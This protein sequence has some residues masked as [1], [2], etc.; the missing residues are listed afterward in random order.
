MIAPGQGQGP[1]DK[2]EAIIQRLPHGVANF[3]ETPAADTNE[4]SL[5]AFKQMLESDIG[6]LEEA[7]G[8]APEEM[9]A[10]I[11]EPL[12]IA[13]AQLQ[14]I[15]SSQEDASFVNQIN[16]ILDEITSAPEGETAAIATTAPIM[17]NEEDLQPVLRRVV[18]NFIRANR[19]LLV[20]QDGSLIK[21]I[22][23]WSRKS[24]IP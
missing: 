14:V 23:S 19:E 8:T 18:V 1:S 7:L 22:S 21:H 17:I 20:K 10:R 11:S 24:K 9:A 13:K 2:V 6:A 15:S 4:S 12:Q 3:V 16:E 5:N